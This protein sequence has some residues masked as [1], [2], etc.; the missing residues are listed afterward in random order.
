MGNVERG[1]VNGL[2][3]EERWRFQNHVDGKSGG[4]RSHVS[5]SPRPEA[6][7]DDQL[8]KNLDNFAFLI[9]VYL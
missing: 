6:E 5:Q 3:E 7:V 8:G 1:K 2:Q 9:I 4:D